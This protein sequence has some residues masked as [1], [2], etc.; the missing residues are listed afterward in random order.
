LLA[1]READV[2]IL[3]CD[4]RGFSKQAEGSRHDLL[5]LL[6]RVSQAMGI[7]TRHILAHGG[8]IGDFLGDAAMGFWGW[9]VASTHGPLDACRAALSIRSEF[10][11]LNQQSNHPLANFQM[12]IGIA[13]GRAVAG[14]IGTAELMKV[15][16]FGPVVNLASRLE[17]MTRQLRVPILLDETVAKDVRQ[18]M[19]TSEARIRHLAKVLPFGMETPLLVSELVP[20][21]S[22]F[23]ELTDG[24]LATYE[25]AVQHFIAGRWEPAYQELHQLPAADQAQDFLALQIAQHNRQAPANWDGM[26][27]LPSK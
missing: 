20:P 13:H 2:T 14:K 1:P 23:P 21:Y 27:R 22:E 19:P 4:L 8:G 18:H 9:P 17:S 3:F 7:V 12:G 10:K 25:R 15:T 6:D 11:S 24:H 26:I 5:G 16:V